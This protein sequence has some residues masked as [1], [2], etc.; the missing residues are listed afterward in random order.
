[1]DSREIAKK[2]AIAALIM[3]IIQLIL[4]TGLVAAPI[5]LAS[6]SKISATKTPY[7][8]GFVCFLPGVLGIIVGCKKS[9]R[10]M[11]INMVVNIVLFIFEGIVRVILLV[12]VRLLVNHGDSKCRRIRDKCTCS[13]VNGGK[14][15]AIITPEACQIIKNETL[16]FHI[17][18]IFFVTA[19]IMTF[20]ASIIGCCSVCRSKKQQGDHVIQHETH[21]MQISQPT[22]VAKI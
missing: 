10:V 22:S 8:A 12:A 18:A 9:H 20:I 21:L 5:Y 13:L 14:Q 3:G 4:G 16:T 15:L 19:T 1:M 7:W 11:I 2:H 6:K 17:V